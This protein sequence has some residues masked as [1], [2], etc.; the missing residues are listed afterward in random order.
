MPRSLVSY[1]KRVALS[2]LTVDGREI[3]PQELRDIAETYNT[4][5]YTATVWLE[6][7]RDFG[8]YGTVFNVR[9][10]ETSPDLQQGQVALEAQIKPND[11]LL[12]LNDRG[13]KLFSSIEIRPNF[14]G[15]GKA[16]LGGL[17]VTDEPAS[18][19]TQEWYFSSTARHPAKRSRAPRRAGHLSVGV[20]LELNDMT[21]ETQ[22][23]T[24][25]A[26]FARL[27]NRFAAGDQQAA[28]STENP[29][30]IPQM[31]EATAT[32]IQGLIEQQLVVTAGF[33]AI[34]DQFA[35]TEP[36]A[37][38]DAVSDVQTAVDSIVTTAEEKQLSRRKPVVAPEG[39]QALQASMTRIEQMFSEA[40]DTPKARPL[41][42][43]T[44]SAPV[45]RVL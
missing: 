31:D 33:Q 14:A 44:R 1:W 11:K 4:S 39:N 37:D 2:G 9:L 24:V 20:P 13:E 23:T 18:L 35:Q 38:A 36:A 30:E 27:F 7:D 5:V 29:T 17:A 16:Y 12:E 6:H 32:A 15:S 34:V 3:L 10:D 41:A 22:L 26:F 8:S 45:K 40:L 28:P 43:T 19:G 21:Q 25:E 42:R